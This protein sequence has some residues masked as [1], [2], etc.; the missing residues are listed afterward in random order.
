MLMEY[1]T[2]VRTLPAPMPT[3]A[4][5][6]RGATRPGPAEPGPARLLHRFAPISLA[7]MDGV[8]LQDRIDTK[9]VLHVDHLYLALAS[10]TEHYQILEIDA[11]RLHRYQTL[12]FDTA[13]F[14]LYRQ[15][16]RRRAGW[17]TARR[18]TRAGTWRSTVGRD[19]NRN[20][21]MSIGSAA[22]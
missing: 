4:R 11:V 15:R 14:A 21:V 20:T 7:Q 8:A 2:R 19:N 16:R 10:L 5:A 6:Q 13:D 22:G 17:T 3:M 9:Y 18:H 1:P 12:Y